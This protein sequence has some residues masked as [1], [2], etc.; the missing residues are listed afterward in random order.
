MRANP[1]EQFYDLHPDY[2]WNR[3]ERHRIEYG[4]TLLAME[5]HLPKPPAKIIDVGGGVGRYAIE[6]ARRG[7]DVTLVDL[8]S[9]ALAFAQAKAREAGVCLA[10][11]IHADAQD[12]SAVAN[13]PFDAA[14]H[15]GPLYHLLEHAERVQT[16]SEVRRLL[17]PGAKVLAA[18]IGRYSIL[19]YAIARAPEFIQR[20]LQENEIVLRTGVFRQVEPDG[21]WDN[22]WLAHPSQIEPL[23]REG[24]FEPVDLLHCEP[25]TYEL[26][27]KIN[28]ASPDLHRQWIDLLYRLARDPSLF[29][30]GG[31]LLHVGRRP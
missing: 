9:K 10:A 28:A 7:Y 4:L 6:L 15:M 24:G 13:G 11:C 20:R 19:Q 25:L 23:M 12:L 3:L 17:R 31:H 21:S 16:L 29:G 1:V 27:E 8:S 26:E 30:G 5:Q 2:E 22:A 18:F 14:L